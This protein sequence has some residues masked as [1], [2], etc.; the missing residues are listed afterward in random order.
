MKTYLVK[1]K[2]EIHTIHKAMALMKVTDGTPTQLQIVGHMPKKYLPINFFDIHYSC[3]TLLQMC[4][5]LDGEN[6]AN[7]WLVVN[8]AKF[9][10]R[11]S[12]PLYSSFL[13]YTFSSLVT[14]FS[15]SMC[16]VVHAHSIKLQYAYIH[17]HAINSN[18][19]VLLM[20]HVY[21]CTV[22]YH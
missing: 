22:L 20:L 14:N 17:T 4:K 8:F 19:I 6:L 10:G 2:Q 16:A 5:N 7:F 3:E 21:V 12:F 18:N 11:Q 13:S 1:N 9:Q 15:I